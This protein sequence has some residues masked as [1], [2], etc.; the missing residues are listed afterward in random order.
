[1]SLPV[2]WLSW[3]SAQRGLYAIFLSDYARAAA[4]LAMTLTTPR[5]TPFPDLHLSVEQLIADDT[6]AFAYT[7]TGT[8]QGPFMGHAPAGKRVQVRGMQRGKFAQAK[9]VERWGSS[10]Q[11]G[12]RCSWTW[13]QPRDVSLAACYAGHTLDTWGVMEMFACG[14]ER[15][16]ATPA[17]RDS[18][19]A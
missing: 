4:P 10:D 3:S 6:V 9:L 14:P 16:A 13:L 12:I 8:H 18:S 19:G 11:L 1:M 5:G 2:S 15:S 7:V 17:S